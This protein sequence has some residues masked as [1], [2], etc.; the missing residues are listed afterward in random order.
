FAVLG[1]AEQGRRRALEDE[2][3]AVRRDP[4]RR[5]RRIARRQPRLL[6]G[7]DVDRPQLTLLE[8]LVVLKDVVFFAT[9]GTLFNRLGLIGEEVDA[10]AVRRPLDRGH[11]RDVRRKRARLSA[12]HRQQLHLRVVLVATFGKKC[13][14]SAVGRPLWA[15]FS[16]FAARELFRVLT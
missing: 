8:L 12:G 9:A 4:E 5:D 13:Q 2:T 3:G 1:V 10:A 16:A 6:A 11:G 15:R 7:R 14:R